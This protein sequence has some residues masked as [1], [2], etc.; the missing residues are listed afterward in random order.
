VP[1]PPR[2][3]PRR[4]LHLAIRG[5]RILGYILISI[6]SLVLIPFLSNL[7]KGTPRLEYLELSSFYMIPGIIYLMCAIFL[8]RRQMLAAILAIAHA[9][10]QLILLL[11]ILVLSFIDFQKV[12][13]AQRPAEL[14]IFPLE[15]IVI[16]AFIRLIYYLSKSF[17]AIKN[18]PPEMRPGFEAIPLAPHPTPLIA[19]SET[20]KPD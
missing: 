8:R 10:A 3:D 20:P 16:L 2:G 7:Q 13:P 14:I 5:T 19:R 1:L 9:A 18:P 11:V 6:G 12:P 17:E 15:L 4:P